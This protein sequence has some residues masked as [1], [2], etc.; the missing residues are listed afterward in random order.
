MAVAHGHL[1]PLPPV[2]PPALVRRGGVVRAVD[3]RAPEGGGGVGRRGGLLGALLA[4]R[5]RRVDAVG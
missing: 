2:G 1:R 5:L 4:A 3:G